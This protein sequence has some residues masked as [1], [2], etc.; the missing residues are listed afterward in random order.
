M[1][2]LMMCILA[3][4]AMS[5]GAQNCSAATLRIGTLKF[6]TVNWELNTIQ[7]HKLDAKYGVT[8]ETTLLASDDA[9]KI[10]LQ[11]G[12][13]DIVVSDWIFV[14]RQRSSGSD[15]S[16]IP[17]SSSVGAIM[18]AENSSMRN[19]ADLTGK[20]LG[21]AGGPLD[22]SWLLLQAFAKNDGLDLASANTLVFGAAPLITEKLRQGE[23]DAALSYWHFNAR[24]EV[25]GYRRLASAID[26]EFALGAEGPV[27]MLGYTFHESWAKENRSLVGGFIKA[28]AEAKRILMS[29]DREWE[30]LHDAG[31]IKDETKTLHALRDHYRAGIPL[32][33][34]VAEEK[35][36]RKLFKTL[37]ELGGDKLVGSARSMPSG[38]FWSE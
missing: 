35:D 5:L 1:V 8:I 37:A 33:T 31:L 12:A 16:F 11:S 29:S 17:Y 38:T 18:V 34:R 24:L 7:A 10:A 4:V 27:S 3:A 32:R 15:L 23:L 30:R 13:V 28:S 9:A 25:D 21:I 2:R 22:K 26:A 14:A 36:A 19:L 20:K 6:G